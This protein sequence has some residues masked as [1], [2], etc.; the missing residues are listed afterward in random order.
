M[1][2][3]GAID[4]YD[5]SAAVGRALRRRLRLGGQSQELVARPVAP[6]ICVK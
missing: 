5:G 2:I 6:V 1:S 4:C 3:G